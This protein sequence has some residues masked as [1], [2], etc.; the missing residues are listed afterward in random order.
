MLGAALV[1]AGL[2]LRVADAA[3]SGSRALFW[4]IGLAF[5]VVCS[6]RHNGLFL[7]AGL[8]LLA[9]VL[10]YQTSGIRS[11][12]VTGLLLFL[13]PVTVALLL[14]RALTD[15]PTYPLASLLSFD[16]SGITV[17]RGGDADFDARYQAPASFALLRPGHKIAE[18]RRW[19]RPNDWLFLTSP[20]SR[21]IQGKPP[22]LLPWDAPRLLALK[23]LW[24]ELVLKYP[25]DYLA[26]RFDVSL[27]LLA[28]GDRLVSDPACFLDRRTVPGTHIDK[29]TTLQ[30]VLGW[31][32]DWVVQKTP[33]F[34]PWLY[35]ALAWLM[36][37]AALILRPYNWQVIA[38]LLVSGLLH[39]SALFFLA[40][41]AEYRYSAWMMVTTVLAAFSLL[42]GL[43]FGIVRPSPFKRVAISAWR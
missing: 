42:G 8:T 5:F 25:E 41:A 14:N 3:R 22:V 31:R 9:G 10:R 20:M 28:W 23:A 7:V 18:L 17:R 40:P 38:G 24:Q 15:T 4:G 30:K 32:L 33:L 12:V 19:Y 1:G 37:G 16:V 2:V 36:L 43:R 21:D 35:Y 26:H 29:R 34:R 27:S 39:E 13:V 11:A 6:V